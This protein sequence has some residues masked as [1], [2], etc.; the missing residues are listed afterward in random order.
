MEPIFRPRRMGHV[1][2]W[3]DD[4]RAAAKWHNDIAGLAEVYRRTD[5]KGAFLSNGNTYHDSA[6]FDLDTPQGKGKKPGL[7]HLA[8]ELENEVELVRGYERL[9]DYGY[10]FD[11]TLS[12]DIAHCCFDASGGRNRWTPGSTPPVAESCYPVDPPIE[13]IEGAVLHTKKASHATLV[14]K[15][16]GVLYRHYTQLV[17]LTPLVGGPDTPFVIL[18]GSVGEQSLAIFAPIPGVEPGLHHGAFELNDPT[19]LDNVEA[20]L[21]E[22]G[23]AT[24]RVTEH[25]ARRSVFIRDINGSLLQYYL[26][27]KEPLSAIAKLK[28]ADAL[29]VA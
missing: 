3:V 16:Y 1:N 25:G 15:D 9:D 7:H 11:F 23:V 24:E 26:A 22:R 14:A 8:F 27:G 2:Y 13:R 5:L 12:A 21:K 28:P 4:W 20:R 18:G 19:D 6:V 29:W 17:G 10:K